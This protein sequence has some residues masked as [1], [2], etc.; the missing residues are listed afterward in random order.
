[1]R[2]GG[3]WHSAVVKF[4]VWFADVSVWLY[5]AMLRFPAPARSSHALFGAGSFLL[6]PHF[7]P[8]NSRSFRY[9]AFFVKHTRVQND[10]DSRA[11]RMSVVKHS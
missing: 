9:K 1:M 3:L 8:L 4:I 11:E 10:R 5:M 2:S 6:A 7:L